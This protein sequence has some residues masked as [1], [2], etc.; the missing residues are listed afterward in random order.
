MKKQ[1]KFD[2]VKA[3]PFDL[4]QPK[5]LETVFKC[6]CGSKIKMKNKFEHLYSIKH[7]EYLEYLETLH[8]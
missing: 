8:R 6:S 3:S 4:Y 5:I 1:Q 2:V 7:R